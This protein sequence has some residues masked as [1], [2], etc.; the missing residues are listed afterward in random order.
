MSRKLK[1]L[2]LIGFLV[3][4]CLLMNPTY[5]AIADQVV[6]EDFV[7]INYPQ[8]IK[9]KKTGCQEIAFP[10]VT[11]E[12]LPRENTA[13]LIAITPIKNKQTYGYAAWFST[14]TYKGENALPPMARI[15]SLKVQICRKAFF[16]SSKS[17]KKTLASSPG[18]YRIIFNATYIDPI[19][20]GPT[21]EKF[22]EIREI[23]FK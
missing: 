6:I 11:S 19:T 9:L 18:K 10:Y 12:N 1:V 15:G 7:T 2:K 4:T 13:F 3:S 20:G 14:Q 17:T 16:Y 21:G 8:S 22:E 5:S 23:V